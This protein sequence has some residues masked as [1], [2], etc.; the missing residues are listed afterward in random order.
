MR[1]NARPCGG[2]DG[3][4]SAFRGG[5]N[6]FFGQREISRGV[7]ALAAAYQKR[8]GPQT[9]Y[10]DRQNCGEERDD[11]SKKRIKVFGGPTGNPVAF[12]LWS[13]VLGALIGGLIGIWGLWCAPRSLPKLA[14]RNQRDEQHDRCDKQPLAARHS[15]YRSAISTCSRPIA[16]ITA[17]KKVVGN[18]PRFTL[19]ATE[20]FVS[21]CPI[22]RSFA[23][24]S[25]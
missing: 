16:F 19:L 12:L 20:I 14:A 22:S 10:G 18:V 4:I 11:A 23:A 25:S 6:D 8:G 2:S 15:F 21:L 13:G 9:D 3:S 24:N 5:F 7:L 1:G 17:T